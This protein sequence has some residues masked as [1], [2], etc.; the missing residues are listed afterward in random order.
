V[1]PVPD[2]LLLT[3]SGSDRNRTRD[4]WT[5]MDRKLTT[6]HKETSKLQNVTGPQSFWQERRTV[7]MVTY[8]Q[9]SSRWGIFWVAEKILKDSAPQSYWPGQKIHSFMEALM[10][11]L[12]IKDNNLKLPWPSSD[13]YPQSE[14]L[15]TVNHINV[16]DICDYELPSCD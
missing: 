11:S 6:Q 8:S 14:N 10:L 16:I 7:N 1:D 12:S 4:L 13:T 15:F 3:K 9:T 5:C 2:P